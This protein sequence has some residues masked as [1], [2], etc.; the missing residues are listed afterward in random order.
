[1][2]FPLFILFLLL[3]LTSVLANADPGDTIWTRTYGGDLSDKAYCIQQTADGGYI[4]AGYTQS[5]GA[6]GFDIYVVRTDSMGDTLWTRTYGGTD[7]D[8]ANSVQQTSDGGYIVGG[9]SAGNMYFFKTGSIGDTLWTR[10]YGSG[11]IGS[12]QQSSDGGYILCGDSGYVK[13]IKTNPIG[14]ILWT[15]TYG[16]G[17]DR[18]YFAQETSD[19]G[20]VVCGSYDSPG[21]NWDIFS[22]KTDSI[23]DTEWIYTDGGNDS[24]AFYCIQQN[25]VNEYI[26]VGFTG[27]SGY[28]EKD[29]LLVQI[30]SEGN[31][32]WIRTYGG[33]NRDIARAIQ[34]TSDNNYI[35]AGETASYGAG[36]ADFYLLKIE[37]EG[38]NGPPEIMN[39]SHV[40]QNPYP[41][42]TCEVSANITDPVLIA[43]VENSL[44]CYNVNGGGY[45]CFQ[46]NNIADSFYA[47]IPGQS[48]GDSVCY[49]II[50]WDDL[51]DTTYSDTTCYEV[52]PIP[53]LTCNT[54]TTTPLVPNVDG[55]IIWSL[56]VMN[57]GPGPVP[58]FAEIYPTVGDC[59][60]GTQYD[61]N[62]NRLVIS[63]LNAGDSTT[64]DYWYRPGTVTS[65]TDA[66]ITIDVGPSID[67]YIGSCCFEFRFAYEFGRPGTE[68]SFGPGEWGEFKREI[69]PITSALVQ[70][71]PNPFN[72]TTN[73]S[74][75]LVEDGNASLQI[76]NLTGQLVETLVDGHMLEGHYNINWDASLYSSG[77]YFYKLITGDKTFAKRMTLLK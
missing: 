37:G 13:V 27:G 75:D 69:I 49:Y 32:S 14:G 21:S 70:N 24:D 38:E 42:Q 66:A 29:I 48:V 17:N 41:E 57:C 54:Y 3:Y 10:T 67:Y 53:C 63:N 64:V 2:K 72:A 68:I 12:V 8:I 77:I 51:D 73:I 25:A 58:V 11:N 7:D 6:G 1:M 47:T 45:T 40:P 28:Y 55:T 60:S 65:V 34:T 9:T 74:F 16:S 71:Y 18:A 23:G 59:A 35:V 5:F 26:A 4:I 56:N 31:P 52:L 33:E 46:M 62:I 39:I 50:A 20:I 43:S 15:N 76:Y 44:L 22:F 36:G 30:D 19:A 61:F